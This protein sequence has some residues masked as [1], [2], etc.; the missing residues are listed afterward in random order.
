MITRL[1]PHYDDPTC[2]SA[3]RAGGLIFLAHHAGGFAERSYA[4][5]TREALESMRHTVEQAGGDMAA[6]VQVTMWVREITDELRAAW[7][8]FAEYFGDEPPAR[9]TA[10]TDFF[11][12]R[13]LVQ[14]DGVA[15]VGEED[16]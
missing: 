14:L 2:A 4:H 7:D 16:R 15:F 5:Q 12:P 11:D 6:V 13:C 8:V 3:V 1:T 10:T 9:M